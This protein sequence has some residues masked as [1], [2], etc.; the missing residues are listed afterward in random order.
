MDNQSPWRNTPR[1]SRVIFLLAVFFVFASFGFANDSINMGNQPAL[2]FAVSV[3]LSGLFAVAYASTGVIL[4]AKWW[5]AAI[6]ICFLQFLSMT[7]L[8]NIWPDAPRLSHFDAA[9]TSSLNSRLIF[10]GCAI[11][12]SVTLGYIGFVYSFISEGRRY[13]RSQTEKASLESEMAAA[14]EVQRVMVPDRL[15][16]I[17]GYA[18]ESIYYPAAEVGGDF[19]QV[20]PLPSG[21]TLVVIGDVSGKG[22]R[23]AM[24]VSMIVGMLYTLT[25]FTE[26]PADILAELNRRLCGRTHGGFVTC[27]V[28]RIEDK[29][30]LTLANAGHL[31]PYINGSET[32]SAGSLPLGLIETAV[33]EQTQLVMQPGDIAVLLTDGMP[34]AQSQQTGLL[35]FTRIE[36]LL[37]DGATVKNLTEIAQQ[38]G[39]NDDLT[40]ISIQ[41]DRLERKQADN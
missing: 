19:F 15:P 20:M 3:I 33:Y 25:G 14:R 38:H 37:R 36:A 4:R 12:I 1:K 6:P 26:E 11:I 40:A 31:P 27:L 39:Q 35:G 28:V 7:L 2:R 10:D 30:R 18:I 23:A 16:A 9:Q 24:I 21:H 41:R 17:D 22:L 13:L 34:E 5:K 8:S 32:P 29:G